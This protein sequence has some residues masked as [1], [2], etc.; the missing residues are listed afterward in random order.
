MDRQIQRLLPRLRQGENY[1]FAQ[2]LDLANPAPTEFALSRET[3]ARVFQAK[4]HYLLPA[5]ARRELTSFCADTD[6]LD[7]AAVGRLLD[8]PGRGE[9]IWYLLNFALWWRK[10]ISA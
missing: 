7:A 2:T 4:F 3:Q 8:T 9:Q 10:F 1:L 5:D 6:L